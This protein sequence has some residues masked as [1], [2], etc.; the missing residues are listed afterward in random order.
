[1]IRMAVIHSF[2]MVSDWCRHQRI[3]I[4]QIYSVV[5]WNITA[6]HICCLGLWEFKY[7][8]VGQTCLFHWS[9]LK[10]ELMTLTSPVAVWLGLSSLKYD[11]LREILTV[12]YIHEEVPVRKEASWLNFP[13]R[14]FLTSTDQYHTHPLVCG[15]RVQGL[16]ETLFQFFYF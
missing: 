7:W 13:F 4:L 9:T 8:R 15:S 3:Q 16:V 14:H 10:I 6:G 2:L 5:K 12:F 1:M 11:V